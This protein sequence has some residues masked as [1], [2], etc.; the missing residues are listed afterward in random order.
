MGPWRAQELLG[1]SQSL[2]CPGKMPGH[3]AQVYPWDVPGQTSPRAVVD[4]TVFGAPSTWGAWPT[5]PN[6]GTSALPW[7]MER[8]GV[9]DWHGCVPFF[10]VSILLIL[11][12]TEF[13]E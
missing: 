5:A 12:A 4:S 7:A 1:A 3:L 10:T 13:E 11:S 9:A 8:R 2:C 6:T